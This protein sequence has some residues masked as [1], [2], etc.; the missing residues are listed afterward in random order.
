MPN[1]PNEP[2]SSSGLRMM[3]ISNLLVF[4]FFSKVSQPLHSSQCFCTDARFIFHLLC[5]VPK[6]HTA[7][8]CFLFVAARARVCV[9]VMLA[10]LQYAY[11]ECGFTVAKVRDSLHNKVHIHTGSYLTTSSPRRRF[12]FDGKYSPKFFRAANCIC[13]S[14]CANHHLCCHWIVLIC[15]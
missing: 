15:W 9:L 11:Q 8:M 5:L 13:P 4:V 3:T 7:I 14:S 10:L 2:A 6:P 1:Q 12:W